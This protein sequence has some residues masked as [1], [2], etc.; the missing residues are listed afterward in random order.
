MT[1]IKLQRCLILSNG[2]DIIVGE[3]SLT[4]IISESVPKIHL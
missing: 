4:Q 2:N 1:L 3:K